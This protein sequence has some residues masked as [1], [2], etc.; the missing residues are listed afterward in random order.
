MIG[1]QCI[2]SA[3]PGHKNLQL[4]QCQHPGGT[5][6]KLVHHICAVNWGESEGVP[7]DIGN[8]CREHT[9][10]TLLDQDKLTLSQNHPKVVPTIQMTTRLKIKMK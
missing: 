7:D 1:I 5:C 6:Q 9:P 3:D 10:V 4:K 8:T 2:V